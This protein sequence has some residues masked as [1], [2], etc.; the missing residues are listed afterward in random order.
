MT[1]TSAGELESGTVQ[2]QTQCAASG[3]PRHMVLSIG[4]FR[5]KMKCWIS[6][7]TINPRFTV[8]QCVISFHFISIICC[9]KEPTTDAVLLLDPQ[10]RVRTGFNVL[11]K[12][13]RP[14]QKAGLAHVLIEH[15]VWNFPHIQ[16]LGQGLAHR[17]LGQR[18]TPEG[19]V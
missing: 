7:R 16:S 12:C 10:N 3:P 11:H 17:V 8:N 19:V 2:S 13:K 5:L 6:S 4:L 15:F 18:R 1:Q 9:G 14:Q